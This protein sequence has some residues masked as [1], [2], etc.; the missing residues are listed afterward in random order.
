MNGSLSCSAN[1]C[2]HYTNNMC[3]ANKIHVSGLNA[4]ITPDT[5][6]STFQERNLEN[7]LNSLSNLNINGEIKQ[8]FTNSGIVMYPEIECDAKAC[9]FNES[10]MCSSQNVNII[11]SDAVN[12]NFTYCNTF[13]K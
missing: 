10:G 8:F 2:V 9:K 3:T 5:H 12:S 11:G 6:C 7:T 13:C 4:S 1:N